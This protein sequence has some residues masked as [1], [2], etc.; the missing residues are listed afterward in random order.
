[1]FE[2]WFGH[3]FEHEY[4]FYAK[5]LNTCSLKLNY[6]VF[7]SIANC[8]TRVCLVRGTG[9]TRFWQCWDGVIPRRE[10]FSQMP[11][12]LVPRKIT[13]KLILSSRRLSPSLAPSSAPPRLR[14][15]VAVGG[16]G[17]G[18]RVTG[19]WAGVGSGRQPPRAG[20]SERQ[21]GGWGSSRRR[22]GRLRAT[23]AYE[24]RIL[25]NT[26]VSDTDTPLILAW[27]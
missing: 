18:L 9:R 13:D 15:T 22:Q 7:C 8:S 16:G 1:M 25:T 10:Y 21:A 24:A 11:S 23:A 27:Y 3:N 12:H 2:K 4:L 20:G 5:I 19:S 14:V 26:L 6:S 17:G